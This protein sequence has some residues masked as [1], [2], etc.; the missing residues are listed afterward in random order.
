MSRRPGIGSVWF[1]R[2]GGHA[3]SLDSV[4]INNRLVRPPR[5]YDTKYELVDSDRLALLKVKRRRK[6]LEH[7]EDQKPDRRR[8]CEEVTIRNLRMFRRDL[9]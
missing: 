9:Q 6:A 1:E 7:R 2:F 5:Y 3:F 4:V 8:V